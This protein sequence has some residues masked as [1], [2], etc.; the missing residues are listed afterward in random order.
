M[1]NWRIRNEFGGNLPKEGMFPLVREIPVALLDTEWG[2]V[3]RG[4]GGLHATISEF[5]ISV[6]ERRFSWSNGAWLVSTP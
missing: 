4:A 3:V 1:R 6:L 2:N 5:L